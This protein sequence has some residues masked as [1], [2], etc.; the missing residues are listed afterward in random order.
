MR[1]L[2]LCLSML[3]CLCATV[4]AHADAPDG[5]FSGNGADRKGPGHGAAWFLG[6]RTVRWCGN[7]EAIA[8]ALESAVRKWSDYV[9]KKKIA[10]ALQA[11]LPF[12][13]R[14]VQQN[15]CD[16]ADLEIQLSADPKANVLSGSELV[17]QDLVHGWGKGRV[18]LNS[19]VLAQPGALETQLLHQLGHILGHDHVGSTVMAEP[20]ADLSATLPVQLSID[21]ARELYLCL[22]CAA[23]WKGTGGMSYREENGAASI[24]GAPIHFTAVLASASH[25]D[26]K[27]F[28]VAVGDWQGHLT[29]QS[30]VRLAVIFDLAGRAQQQIVRRNFEKLVEI[31]RLENGRA[32]HYFEAS[33]E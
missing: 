29:S 12:A 31:D 4:P 1:T 23:S 16:G 9:E 15:S 3:L 5:S 2:R 13:L 33:G 11:P 19:A 27:L 6:D 10:Q 30:L 20:I 14:F 25:G 26:A 22:A 24:N 8:P 21:G 28:T 17:E 7:H 32:V 18:W